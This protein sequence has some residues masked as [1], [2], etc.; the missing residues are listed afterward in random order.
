MHGCTDACGGWIPSVWQTY[1]VCLLLSL[2][3]CDVSLLVCSPWASLWYVRP[4]VSVA[5]AALALA[6]YCWL[7]RVVRMRPAVWLPAPSL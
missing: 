1:T 2:P 5:E 6:G 3:G 7:L 4:A